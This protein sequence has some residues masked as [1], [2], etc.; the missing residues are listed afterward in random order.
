MF[1]SLRFPLWLSAALLSGLLVAASGGYA[2][3][4]N[5]D[6]PANTGM[7]EK[8]RSEQQKFL[9]DFEG[10]SPR[11][12]TGEL[13]PVLFRTIQRLSSYAAPVEFPVIKRLPADALNRMA[14]KGSCGVLG[15]YAGGRE[16]YLDSRLAPETNLFDRSVLLHEMV[17][18]LQNLQ[19][20]SPIGAREAA[21]D[22]EKCRL[23]YTR[24]RE[25]YRIQESY[26]IM[27]SSPVRAGFFPA[28]APC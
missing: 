15:N 20:E 22:A 3:D 16:I 21:G 12:E 28:R 11:L 8:Y 23:W 27:V 4:T 1:R 13:L 5:A 10:A 24:E 18:Y 6:V 9:D 2:A 26:L 14:C 25:A 17:H 19:G 7:Y